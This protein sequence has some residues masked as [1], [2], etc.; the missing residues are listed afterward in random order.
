VHSLHSPDAELDEFAPPDPR[1]AQLLVQVLAGV[2][3]AAGSDDPE[4]EESFDLRVITPRA[5]QR[6]LREQ[7]RPLVGRHLVIVD[8]WD[9]PT[10]AA[11]LFERFE[12]EEGADWDDLG[13]RLNRFGRWEF[14]D[15]DESRNSWDIPPGVGAAVR[16]LTVAGRNLADFAPPDQRDFRVPVQARIAAVKGAGEGT[17]TVEV[18]TPPALERRVRSEGIIL[19]EHLLIV[20]HW[21]TAA[22]TAAVT[23]MFQSQDGATWS[24]VADRLARYGAPEP[25]SG[26]I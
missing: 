6:R 2:R 1:D 3:L 26:S 5:A 7:D 10:I 23:R 21:D 25:E 4:G 12:S 19:G 9:Y 11:Y 24:E 18:C 8:Q 15:F 20:D 22:I 16:S 17:F 14:E 13:T